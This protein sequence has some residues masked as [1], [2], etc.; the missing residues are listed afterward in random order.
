MLG[1]FDDGPRER[2]ECEQCAKINKQ[3][4]KMVKGQQKLLAAYR[5]G[6]HRTPGK[7]I[8]DITAAREALQKL[9]VQL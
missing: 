9:G 8:D 7:A 1:P 2:E 4:L 6:G 3:L 5:S